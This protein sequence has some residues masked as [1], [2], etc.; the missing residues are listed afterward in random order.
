[1]F[2]KKSTH[3]DC[4]VTKLAFKTS[5]GVRRVVPMERSEVRILTTSA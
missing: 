3:F 5:G 2:I 4:L 1:M